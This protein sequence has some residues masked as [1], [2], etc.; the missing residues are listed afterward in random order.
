M[1]SDVTR[2]EF[3]QLATRTSILEGEVGGE[4]L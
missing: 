1:P 3:D 2:D 4:K